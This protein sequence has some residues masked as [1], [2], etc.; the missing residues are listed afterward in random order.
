MCVVA[1]SSW[2]VKTMLQVIASEAIRGREFLFVGIIPSFLSPTDERSAAEQFDAN[3]ISGWSP[4][5]GWEFSAITLELRF[6]GDPSM[7]PVAEIQWDHP[8]G[9]RILI[10]PHAWV[11]ILQRD[12]SFEVSRLD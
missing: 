10:Y 2:R 12:G 1:S 8:R 3:Y 7:R 5:D 11:L 9:E 6:P 4:M